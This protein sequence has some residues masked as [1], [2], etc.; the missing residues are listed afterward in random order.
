LV[1]E[2]DLDSLPTEQANTLYWTQ[3]TIEEPDAFEEWE[4]ASTAWFEELK[5]ALAQAVDRL[6]TALRPP[7]RIRA[8]TTHT[9][10][11]HR[12]VMVTLVHPKASPGVHSYLQEKVVFVHAR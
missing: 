4:A 6:W 12:S 1:A 3:P 11:T 2:T 8:V 9:L 10:P 5:S 7:G